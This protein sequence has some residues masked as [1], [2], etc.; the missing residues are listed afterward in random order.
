MAMRF[1]LHIYNPKVIWLP[2]RTTN[3]DI[4]VYV[5][6]HKLTFNSKDTFQVTL[7]FT[8]RSNAVSWNRTDFF[9]GPDINIT[10]FHL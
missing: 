7:K 4:P 5:C 6:K 10:A 1:Y 9:P 8:R 3:P 2:I